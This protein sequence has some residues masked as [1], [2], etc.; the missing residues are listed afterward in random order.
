ML[1][2]PHSTYCSCCVQE[3]N[4][5]PQDVPL[6]LFLTS[7]VR[8]RGQVCFFNDR[9]KRVLQQWPSRNGTEAS[10]MGFSPLN[11]TWT[12]LWD[13]EVTKIRIK[14]KERL[15]CKLPIPIGWTCNLFCNGATVLATAMPLTSLLHCLKLPGESGSI[16][17]PISWHVLHSETH[18]LK[19][20]REASQN[21][22]T[23]WPCQKANHSINE[24][25]G[26]PQSQRAKHPFKLPAGK[27]SLL[28]LHDRLLLLLTVAIKLYLLMHSETK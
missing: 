11:L 18:F 8:S 19:V 5:S 2:R 21:A 26:A 27:K 22:A 28:H 14:M 12:N 16:R 1:R 25:I 24:H 3:L 10:V 20:C 6:L 13:S 15:I 4:Q 7:Q 17:Q 23:G 9:V